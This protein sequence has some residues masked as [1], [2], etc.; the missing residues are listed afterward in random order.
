MIQVE[1]CTKQKL[2]NLILEHVNSNK[3]LKAEDI[4]FK[5]LKDELDIIVGLG[6]RSLSA[7]KEIDDLRGSLIWWTKKLIVKMVKESKLNLERFTK[8]TWRIVN[9]E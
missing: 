9:N 8:K 4:V 7:H 2:K 6:N 3:Y 5:Y 1:E